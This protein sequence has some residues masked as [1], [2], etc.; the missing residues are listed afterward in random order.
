M[1]RDNG[2]WERRRNA[3]F[4]NKRMV[5]H[6]DKDKLK[7]KPCK[8]IIIEEEP[9]LAPPASGKHLADVIARLSPEKI[10]VVLGHLPSSTVQ[11]LV[12]SIVAQQTLS[13]S[14]GASSEFC[15]WRFFPGVFQNF[16]KQS[17]CPQQFCLWP[18][19]ERQLQS[20]SSPL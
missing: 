20:S 3:T 6:K 17:F 2:I 1:S 7:V 8:T 15:G 4:K 9:P 11:N 18:D 16:E 13:Q 5:K 10:D 14:S 12:Q 19:F